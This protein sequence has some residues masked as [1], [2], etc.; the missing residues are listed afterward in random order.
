MPKVIKV[1]CINFS[2]MPDLLSDNNWFLI[3]L[4]FSLIAPWQSIFYQYTLTFYKPSTAFPNRL[5]EDKR[6]LAA[7]C[8]E[9]RAAETELTQAPL[10]F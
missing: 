6:A 2:G 3:D 10:A 8:A 7:C 9:L 4:N 5:F 1:F